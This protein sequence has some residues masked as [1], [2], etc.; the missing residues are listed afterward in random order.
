MTCHSYW[1][2]PSTLLLPFIHP[3]SNSFNA[4]AAIGHRQLEGLHASMK[5]DAI[6][7]LGTFLYTRF[8]YDTDTT[9]KSTVCNITYPNEIRRRKVCDA[10]NDVTRR[11]ENLDEKRNAKIKSSKVIRCASEPQN[12]NAVEAQKRVR[13]RAERRQRRKRN[14]N[15]YFYTA[16][17][18]SAVAATAA[19]IFI[20]FRLLEC[21]RAEDQLF[22]FFFCFG[23]WTSWTLA[24]CIHA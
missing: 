12:S 2:E 18:S 7:I 4:I 14:D 24:Q 16:S 9:H 19:Y 1:W 10:Y 23:C 22:F 21:V 13:E 6:D 3:T 17:V 11:W 8:D 5:M 20:A 15:S